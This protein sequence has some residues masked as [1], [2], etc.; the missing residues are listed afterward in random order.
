MR[1]C[2]RQRLWGSLGI[3]LLPPPAPFSMVLPAPGCSQALHHH[4]CCFRQLTVSWKENSTVY[5]T[6]PSLF[7]HFSTLTTGSSAHGSFSSATQAL[8]LSATLRSCTS[9]LVTCHHFTLHKK[10]TI[11][12]IKQLYT[13][14][15]Q[16][17]IT[18]L[19]VSSPMSQNTKSHQ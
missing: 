6:P 14:Q 13:Y 17:K 9:A 4:P 16:K 15:N 11:K 10:P 12:S 19:L 5:N 7:Q 8:P 1:T 3:E 2:V 18:L